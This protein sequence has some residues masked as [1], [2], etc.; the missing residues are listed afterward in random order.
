MPLLEVTG[1]TAS[2]GMGNVLNSIDLSVKTGELVGIVGPNG[3]GKTTLMRAISGLMPRSSSNL[4]V[5]ASLARHPSVL[6]K[7]ALFM[8]RRATLSIRT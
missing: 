3:H 6:R 4:M 1:L 2:Y 8:Y 7:R 5:K